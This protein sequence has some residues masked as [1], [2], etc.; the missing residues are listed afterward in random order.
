MCAL[1]EDKLNYNRGQLCY[2]CVRD[3]TTFQIAQCNYRYSNRTYDSWTVQ[4]FQLNEHGEPEYPESDYENYTGRKSN[5]NQRS[6]NL[7][8]YF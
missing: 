4:P 5:R 3:Q 7:D 1:S 8:K 2:K 6:E